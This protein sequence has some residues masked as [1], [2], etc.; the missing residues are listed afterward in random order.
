MTRSTIPRIVV[1]VLLLLTW[2][3]TTQTRPTIVRAASPPQGPSNG[4][5]QNGQAPQVIGVTPYTSP[6]LDT[7]NGFTPYGNGD[8][9]NMTLGDCALTP[10]A[11]GSSFGPGP[12]NFTNPVWYT[13]T[14]SSNGSVTADT[15]RSNYDTAIGVYVATTSPPASGGDFSEIACNNNAD[16]LPSGQE[17]SLVSFPVTAGVTYYIMV[18]AASPN[19]DQYPGTWGGN[20]RFHVVAGSLDGF[21]FSQTGVEGKALANVPIATFIDPDKSSCASYTAAVQID[22]TLETAS[23]LNPAPDLTVSCTTDSTN[24]VCTVYSTHVYAEETNSSTGPGQ[25]NDIN[26]QI[27]D[28]DGDTLTLDSTVTIADAQLTF[29]QNGDTLAASEMT[30]VYGYLGTFTDQA[31][32]SADGN[33]KYCDPAD[34]TAKVNWG[35]SDNN[36]GGYQSTI[37]ST[38]TPAGQNQIVPSTHKSGPCTFDVYGTHTYTSTGSGGVYTNPLPRNITVTVTDAGLPAPCFNPGCTP[39][40]TLYAKANVS[41]A[42]VVG[43]GIPVATSQLEGQQFSAPILLGTVTDTDAS[44]PAQNL[45]ITINWGDGS[46]TDGL[47][48][49]STTSANSAVS[50]TKPVAGSNPCVYNIYGLH[51]YSE[52]NATGKS[53]TVSV[54]GDIEGG[55]TWAFSTTITVTDSALN[56][57]N[58]HN[59]MTGVLTGIANPTEGAPVVSSYPGQ[60]ANTVYLGTVH[61]QAMNPAGTPPPDTP[62]TS[63]DINDLTVTVDWGDDSVNPAGH[64]TTLTAASGGIAP[65]TD[66]KPCD[67]DLFGTYTYKEETTGTPYTVTVTTA[68]AGGSTVTGFDSITVNNAPLTLVSAATLTV[69]EDRTMP[70]RALGVFHD[71][72]PN[73]LASDYTASG[74]WGDGDPIAGTTGPNAD[75][76]IH[77]LGSN[78]D[79]EV[80]GTHAF[81]NTGTPYAVTLV[82]TDGPSPTAPGATS[83]AL[84]PTVNVNDAPLSVVANAT[85]TGT[86]DVNTGT[87]GLGTFQ[88]NAPNCATTTADANA[89]FSVSIDWG[90]GSPADPAT[91]ELVWT[92][93]CQYQVTGSHLYKEEDANG[94]YIAKATVT[95][96]VGGASVTLQAGGTIADAALT[97]GAPVPAIPFVENT[98]IGKTLVGTFVDAAVPDC[99]LND[100]SGV[101]A[102]GDGS[103]TPVSP[104]NGTIT[105]GT[106]T[107]TFNV[108]GDHTYTETGPFNVQVTIADKGGATVTLTNQ[109]TPSQDAPLTVVR[110][111]VAVTGVEGAPQ[112]AIYLGEFHDTAST[113]TLADYTATVNWNVAGGGP[114]TTLTGFNGGIVDL[115][116]GYCDFKLYGDYTYAEEG[117][118]TIGIVVDDAQGATVSLT[119]TA[120]IADAALTSTPLPAQYFATEGNPDTKRVL[121][122]IHDADPNCNANDYTV[123]IDWGDGTSLDT[124]TGNVEVGSPPNPTP[125]SC[126]FTIT[127]SHTYAEETSKTPYQVTV[128]VIDDAPT[129]SATTFVDYANV[130]DAPLT[131][132]ANANVAV[133]GAPVTNVLL[134]T[135]TDADPGCALSD[136]TVTILWNDSPF[137]DRTHGYLQKQSGCT[138]NVYA[139]SHT[140]PEE[141]ANTAQVTITD[142][143]SST[144]SFTSTFTTADAALTSIAV[145]PTAVEG[146]PFT[147]KVIGT[148]SDAD[149]L[150]GENGADYRLTS[151]DW[152]DGTGLDSTSGQ[153]VYTGSKCVFNITGNHVFPEEGTFH[154]T[155]TVQDDGGSTLAIDTTVVVSDAALSAGPTLT[156]NQVEGQQFNDVVLGTFTDADPGC[157]PAAPPGTSDYTASINWGDGSAASTGTITRVSG[158]TFQITGSHLYREEKT[159]GYNVTVT[160]TDSGGATTTVP[161]IIIVKDAPLTGLA[162]LSTQNC[163]LLTSCTLSGT[164][165]A[166]SIAAFHDTSTACTDE[167]TADY[168]V[169]IDWGDGSPID[170]T[171]GTITP[172]SPASSCDFYVGG[173][174][175]YTTPS[176]T[177]Y[178]IT[179]TIKDE[180]GSQYTTSV[181]PDESAGTVTVGVP[182]SSTHRG[183][184]PNTMT[185]NY[186][187][188]STLRPTQYQTVLSVSQYNNGLFQ[189]KMTFKDVANGINAQNCLLTTAN[190][191]CRLTILSFVCVPGTKPT[192]TLWAK[193]QTGTTTRYLRFDLTTGGT[194]KVTTQSPTNNTVILT[195][196][197]P[198]PP[199]AVGVRIRCTP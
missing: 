115:K 107:C 81:A 4:D 80:D 106:G 71:T 127:G 53:Y 119:D 191:T 17:T 170:T 134:G 54:S 85:F 47:A 18:V 149:P 114:T 33:T 187:Y 136:Y 41:D 147:N 104:S 79:F 56:Y 10:W 193:Y 28:A 23:C 63:C 48:S 126:D 58:Y 13:Y 29:D 176:A 82:I 121:G 87:V 196:S 25:G 165:L 175:T 102:W 44:C 141:G 166:T 78:C 152:G 38:T 159:T 111:N 21:G 77:F 65:S 92:A 153:I 195:S 113:C 45:D 95:D 9:P 164:S 50:Y 117:T 11:T 173:A 172:A 137:Y 161:A 8:E 99:D 197:P 122:T 157:G 162:N 16:G 133:E 190:T 98:P 105:A 198:T 116:D 94:P 168:T 97:A 14:P 74:N 1:V 138:Y 192:G 178:T 132:T 185:I 73:C 36:P 101:I 30:P 130:N 86:E 118:Y 31:G 68:D 76:Q 12:G 75:I 57:V 142:A 184:L 171:T 146:A 3:L 32:I 90:D 91:G 103:T 143:S 5:Y 2:G 112:T 156:L 144:T 64:V 139:D 89:E 148:F 39:S 194:F 181:S 26:V 110:Q 55:A 123:Q 180:G 167:G 22:G 163:T 140:F 52:E 179:V 72:D 59:P 7:T 69:G 62:V 124:I 84:N 46:S 93:S 37:T 108:Y 177:G 70:F 158:C 100:Y 188:P 88:D 40:V 60:P 61:D 49:P 135:F 43:S 67:F 183:G 160:V 189:G 154:V 66:G 51:T 83:V 186:G 155:F 15:F 34:Y 109:A 96:M 169:S 6:I 128:T 131:S 199:T 120:T 182:A 125:A 145:S 35:D 129:G 174:H 19:N 20:L 150:C 42:T 151:I 24:T 27:Y